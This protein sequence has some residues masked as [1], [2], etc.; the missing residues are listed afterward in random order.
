MVRVRCARH[1]R[2]RCVW[3]C[4]VVPQATC[5]AEACRM[6]SSSSFGEQSRSH[7]RHES[8]SSDRTLMGDRN[9]RGTVR[10]IAFRWAG[11]MSSRLRTICAIASGRESVSRGSRIP[12][13]SLDTVI[14]LGVS[15]LTTRGSADIYISFPFQKETFCQRTSLSCRRIPRSIYRRREQNYE[16]RFNPAGRRAGKCATAPRGQAP[17]AYL[18]TRIG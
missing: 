14:S 16:R 3:G 6:L 1:A 11:G 5:A 7:S 10:R 13:G 12:S 9:A 2:V 15:C 17:H 4:C 8:K 18:P